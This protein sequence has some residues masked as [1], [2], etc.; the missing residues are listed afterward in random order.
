MEELAERRT[1][2]TADTISIPFWVNGVSCGQYKTELHLASSHLDSTL[3]ETLA[4]L[5]R[6]YGLKLE[7]KHEGWLGF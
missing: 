6:R 3:S 4:I 7:S 2:L 1:V 5:T